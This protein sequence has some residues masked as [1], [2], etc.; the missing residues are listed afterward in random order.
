MSLTKGTLYKQAS[1]QYYYPGLD[2]LKIL[3]ATI[4]VLR[5]CGQSFFAHGSIFK[6][7]V[8]NTISPVAVPTFFLISS[9]LFFNKHVDDNNLRK[10]LLRLLVLYGV[11][12]VM[13]LP[14]ILFDLPKTLTGGIQLLQR[15]VFDGSYFHLWYLPSLMFAILLTYILSKWINDRALLALSMLLFVL[16]TF[17][18]TYN[19]I[20][21]ILNWRLYKTVF[22]TTRNGVFFGFVFV[23]LGKI[24]SAGIFR[25]KVS[26]RAFIVSVCL[27]VTES[28]FLSVFKDK[29]LINMTFSSLFLSFF[30]VSIFKDLNV[31]ANKT[32]LRTIRNMSTI[33]FCLHP[34][35]M[36]V[37]AYI[38][39]KLGMD[40]ISLTIMVLT[41]TI[42][43][44]W[45]IEKL[46][47]NLVILRKLY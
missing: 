3:L 12:T 17:V 34:W 14:L 47:N 40:G 19:F 27:V 32:T 6:I 46:S 18:E 23:V 24:I 13:Y 31:K 2:V 37:F 1:K 22:I 28:I 25:T 43:C 39:H 16:G 42:L 7:V 45:I 15:F 8:T 4:V 30:L 35:I 21:P 33:I 10:Y 44:A 36:R 26:V 5:H 11:W 9:F 41:V 29:N 20:S 38:N